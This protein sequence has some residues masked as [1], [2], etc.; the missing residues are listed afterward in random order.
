MVIKYAWKFNLLGLFRLSTGI[1][2]AIAV[3][4]GPMAGYATYHVKM[5][6]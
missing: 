1:L 6:I 3:G 5:F 4:R 2:L